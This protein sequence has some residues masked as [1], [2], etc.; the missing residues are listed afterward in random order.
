[1]KAIDTPV[2]VRIIVLD[3]AK[4]AQ[5][6][7]SFIKKQQEVFISLTVISQTVDVLIHS[8]NFTKKE[9]IAALE[10]ILKTN[11]FYI[12]HSELVWKAVAEYKKHN[13][14]FADCILGV[15]AKHYGAES[16]ATFDKKAAQTHLFELIT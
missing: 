7:R 3:D 6:A 15:T 4:Q 14:D 2:L 16:V 1:M 5:L 8:Y 10:L 13:M 12:E 9:I 11:Q